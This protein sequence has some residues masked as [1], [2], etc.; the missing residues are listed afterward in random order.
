MLYTHHLCEAPS[1]NE[2]LLAQ[3]T[4]QKVN[5][6]MVL[7]PFYQLPSTS[8][9]PFPSSTQPSSP[10][11]CPATK[12]DTGGAVLVVVQITGLHPPTMP[13]LGFRHE[14]AVVLTT[15]SQAM[16]MHLRA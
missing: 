15:S 5:P 14:R 3:P 10:Y 6:L 8:L 2:P 13:V 12:P 11:E 1:T 16:L 7:P 4:P 9:S